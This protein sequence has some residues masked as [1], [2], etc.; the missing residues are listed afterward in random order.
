[1]S[2][3]REV[4][5]DNTIE[6]AIKT[7]IQTLNLERLPTQRELRSFYNNENLIS[8]MTKSGGHKRW[9]K[10]LDLPICKNSY[11]SNVEIS[12][13]CIEKVIKKIKNETKLIAV[14]MGNNSP[15]SLLI[16]NSVKISVMTSKAYQDT[17]KPCHVFLFTRK[18]QKADIYIFCL[19][20]EFS[21][22]EKT[23]I[24]PCVEIRHAKLKITD[25]HML[26]KY[27][28]QYSLIQKFDTFYKGLKI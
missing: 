11:A 5:N 15:Y 22:I 28:D 1:M 23:L 24:V 13:A 25:K 2:Y 20:N 6:V 16:N 17:R 8:A 4:W 21:Q 19:L 18:Y 12:N 7:V 9:S 27:E 14:Y 26:N 3:K 10:Q